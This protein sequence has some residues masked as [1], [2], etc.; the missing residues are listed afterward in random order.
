MGADLAEN[1][2]TAQHVA[3]LF[4]V[5]L[6]Q[7]VLEGMR[8]TYERDKERKKDSEGEDMKYIIP[9]LISTGVLH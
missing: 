7:Q 4:F 3:R 5:V 2:R 8:K 9:R 1:I 6:L